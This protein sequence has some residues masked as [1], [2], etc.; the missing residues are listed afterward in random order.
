M[1]SRQ[2]ICRGPQAIERLQQLSHPQVVSAL[3]DPLLPSTAS[4]LEALKRPGASLVV[5]L[6][7]PAEPILASQ[8]RAELVAALRC[9]DLVVIPDGVTFPVEHALAEEHESASREFVAHVL[10]RMS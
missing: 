3:F 6:G 5:V 1:D 9:V 10:E 8:A 2:K 7:E 4:R